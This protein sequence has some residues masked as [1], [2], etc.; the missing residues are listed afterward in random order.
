M[1]CVLEASKLGKVAWQRLNK[2]PGFFR[3]EI[4]SVY[5]H[6]INLKLNNLQMLSVTAKN[7]TSPIAIT[8]DPLTFLQTLKSFERCARAK[9]VIK[10]RLG[11]GKVTLKLL[12]CDMII[13]LNNAYLLP[14]IPLERVRADILTKVGWDIIRK[15]TREFCTLASLL[16]KFIDSFILTKMMETIREVRNLINLFSKTAHLPETAYSLIGLGS[17]ATPSYD[18]F[19]S[20]FIGSIN[21]ISQ[22]ITHHK[23]IV[24]DPFKIFGRTTE[25]SAFLLIESLDGKLPY[26]L[27]MGFHT[28]LKNDINRS[29][30]SLMDLLHYGHDSGIYLFAGFIAGLLTLKGLLT[31]K[32]VDGIHERIEDSFQNIIHPCI[33]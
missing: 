7:I 15:E 19:L 21:Y 9:E 18:D 29:I 22:S 26:S 28:L 5:P 31:Q 6:T 33:N 12:S 23:L 24:Y 25:T 8:L 17:G 2:R 4:I 27:L 16:K 11:N 10:I 30:H 3:T 32:A 1:K 13:K 14:D 20:G